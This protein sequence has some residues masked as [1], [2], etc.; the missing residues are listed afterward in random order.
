MSLIGRA[1]RIKYLSQ[2]KLIL[3]DLGGIK[4]NSEI[5]DDYIKG[6]KSSFGRNKNCKF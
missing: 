2:K 6:F 1:F 5:L 4:C 3:D